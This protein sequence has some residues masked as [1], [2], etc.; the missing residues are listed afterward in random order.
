MKN[1]RDQ[2]CEK[3]PVIEQTMVKE[4]QARVQGDN[5]LVQAIESFTRQLQ[6]S[7]FWKWL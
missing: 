2:I 5:T 3:F 4:T 7:S 1:T 6:V